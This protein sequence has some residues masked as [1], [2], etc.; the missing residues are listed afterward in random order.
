MIGEND[1]APA[2]SLARDGGET[3]SLTD[4]QGKYIVLYFYPKDNTPGC[5]TEANEFTASIDQFKA[6]NCVIL[7]V[8]PDTVK[9]HENFVKKYDLKVT[10]LADT[11]KELAEAYGVWIEKK[12][13][14]RTYMGINR[15]TFIIDPEGKIVKEWRKVKVKGHVAEVL[16]TLQSLTS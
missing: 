16:E 8:S 1:N 14:G 9:K 4:F 3:V 13:Y 11:E 2:F 12:M 7:G 10:L 5:T 15:S 6:L